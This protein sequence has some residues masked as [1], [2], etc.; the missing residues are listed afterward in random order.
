[1][2]L[3]VLGDVPIHQPG[4][5]D[6]KREQRL[7]NSKERQHVWVQNVLPP[8]DLTVEPLVGCQFEFALE[9]VIVTH[10]FDFVQISRGPGLKCLHAHLVS[11]QLA[12][13]NICESSR[14]I[15]NS[16]T[17]CYSREEVRFGQDTMCW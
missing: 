15:R 14:S 13:P 4:T 9:Q 10:P 8:Y 11:I 16:V 7:R 1:M 5:D 2:F 6:T 3:D 12:L 17:Q